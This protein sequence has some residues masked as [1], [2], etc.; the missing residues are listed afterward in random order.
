MSRTNNP[1]FN[2]R[3]KKEK[4]KSNDPKPKIK[5]FPNREAY[6]Q[7]VLKWNKRRKDRIAKQKN[8]ELKQKGLVKTSRGLKKRK[9]NNSLKVKPKGPFAKDRVGKPDLTSSSYKEAK[10]VN[11]SLKINKKKKVENKEVENKSNVKTQEYKYKQVTQEEL[12]KKLAENK[13][14]EAKKEKKIPKGSA[15]NFI[16]TKKGFARRGTPMA[17]RA[18]ERE[19]A[20]IRLA[21]K[22]YMKNR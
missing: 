8:E 4:P 16:K 12:D 19:K 21:A 11:E 7:A 1:K 6:R 15:R 14:P 17:K 9:T 10:A 20:R 5:D 3:V 13:K 2:N 22:G 18:E